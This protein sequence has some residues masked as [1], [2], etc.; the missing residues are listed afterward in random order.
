MSDGNL[1]RGTVQDRV[2]A[3]APEA[4]PGSP[5]VAT[6]G[7]GRVESTAHL[8]ISEYMQGINESADDGDEGDSL[9]F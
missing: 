4:Q 5:R 6:K 8:T 3:R 2:I 9:F 7:F 1:V